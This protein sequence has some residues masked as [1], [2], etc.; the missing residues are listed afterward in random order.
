MNNTC[1]LE[2]GAQDGGGLT[3]IY[4]GSFGASLTNF[5]LSNVVGIDSLSSAVD[6]S[7]IL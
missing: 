6:N 5:S 1:L 4:T 7:C 3:E 2:S